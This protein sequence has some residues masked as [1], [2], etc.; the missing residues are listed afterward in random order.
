MV[1][2]GGPEGAYY[3]LAPQMAAVEDAQLAEV[4]TE[5]QT[6][7]DIEILTRDSA[8]LPIT[9]D[10]RDFHCTIVI[11]SNT[12]EERR[13]VPGPTRR[14]AERQIKDII[15]EVKIANY[16]VEDENGDYITNVSQIQSGQTL[17]MKSVDAAAR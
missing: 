5:N 10:A 8:N 2:E 9:N 4:I 11:K 3:R 17:V 15:A 16:M 6:T 12:G 14:D 13:E 1:R 7:S